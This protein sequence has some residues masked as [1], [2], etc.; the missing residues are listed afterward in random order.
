MQFNINKTQENVLYGLSIGEEKWLEFNPGEYLSSIYYNN[1]INELNFIKLVT[2]LG[3][4]LVIGED[5]EEIDC[6]ELIEI[7]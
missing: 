3:T 2:N 6:I 7:S 1:N 5:P 4:M